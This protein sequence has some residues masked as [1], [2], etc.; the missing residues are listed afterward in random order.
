M[1]RTLLPPADDEAP[2]TP[3]F[4]NMNRRRRRTGGHRKRPHYEPLDPPPRDQTRGRSPA[5]RYDDN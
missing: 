3:Q 2:I 5:D 4:S 1:R